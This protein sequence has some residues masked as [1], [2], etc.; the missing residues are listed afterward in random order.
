MRIKTIVVITMILL[1]INLVVSVTNLIVTLDIQSSLEQP[2]VEVGECNAGFV[3]DTNNKIV[4]LSDFYPE[5]N[6]Y[7][8]LIM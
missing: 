2:E 3:Y 6:Y 1:I 5:N 8:K 7:D 4:E